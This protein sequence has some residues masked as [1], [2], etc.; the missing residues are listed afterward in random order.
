MQV[1][2][3]VVSVDSVGAQTYSATKIATG[4]A[5]PFAAIAAAAITTL[6][7]SAHSLHAETISPKERRTAVQQPD[8]V[9]TAKAA[10]AKA[11]RFFTDNVAVDGTY[12]WEY[13]PDLTDRFG[14]QPAKSRQGWIQPPGSPTIG[15]AYLQAYSDTGERFY[16]EAAQHVGTAL[17]A[18]QL[19]SGG[20]WYWGEFDPNERQ[21]WCFRKDMG[22]CTMLPLN[23]L[24]NAT[25]IDDNT[26]QSALAFLILLDLAV[27]SGDDNVKE[28]INYALSHIRAAQYPNG[29]FPIRFDLRSDKV[30]TATDANVPA[31]I[32]QARFHLGDL[33]FTVNDNAQRD[34]MR[35]MLI[36]HRAYHDPADLEAAKRVGDFLI[37]ARLPE[38]QPAWAQT[39]NERL[40]PA[41]GRRFE[42]AAVVS[43]ETAGSVEALLELHL[44]TGEEKYLAPI[45][46]AV[47]WL[48]KAQLPDG[49][50]ARFYEVGSN[51]PLYMTQDYD[52]TYEANDLPTHYGFKGAYDIPAILKRVYD[53]KAQGRDAVN[54]TVESPPDWTA[55]AR[56]AV[57]AEQAA[58]IA[59][60]LDESG[61]WIDKGRISSATFAANMAILGAYVAY[62]EH[63]TP[64]DWQTLLPFTGYIGG[65]RR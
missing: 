61:R 39:Y 21:K 18:T 33:F 31:I 48:E 11:A 50:W 37:S 29:A 52:L 43:N 57:L 9:A 3:G 60:A 51:R 56:F 14:E 24:K 35:T 23:R 30:S 15:L 44:Y 6:L 38:P 62:A 54:A 4:R 22:S 63:R 8:L 36:A 46:S 53:F 12:V 17:L 13:S 47:A 59:N 2:L 5:A 64:D 7:M 40:E 65:T 32:S 16:L 10:M 25:T 28:A 49:L 26:T 34:M 58:L 45:D 41:W 20:W 19:Q 27:P 42:P 55:H 1:M